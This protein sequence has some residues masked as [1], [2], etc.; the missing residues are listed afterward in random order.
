ML[1]FFSYLSWLQ[2]AL[3]MVGFMSGILSTVREFVLIV[4]P[5][6]VKE[7][8]LF[9]RC[10][11]IAF[12]LS[13]CALWII[14]HHKTLV[15]EAAGNQLQGKLDALTKPEFELTYGTL[16]IGRENYAVG[17]KPYQY[18]TVFLPVTVLNHGAPSV[19]RRWRMMATL[20]NGEV[21]TGRPFVPSSPIHGPN[22]FKLMGGAEGPISIP[23]DSSLF[24]TG[25]AKPIPQGGQASGYVMFIFPI[26][27][28]GQMQTIGTM[29]DFTLYDV[30][31]K[32]YHQS[33]PAGGKSDA[34]FYGVPGMHP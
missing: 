2:I 28:L 13:S 9:W 31:D 27:I 25:T 26:E 22:I 33:I 10:V 21:Y 29:L 30:S 14:E 16:V 15:L 3:L 8:F 20:P 18:S 11:V 1:N 17:G 5:D 7:G 19:V 32:P 6:K 24:L 34:T 23:I 12:I 4:K